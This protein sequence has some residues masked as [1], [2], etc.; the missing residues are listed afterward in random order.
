[1]TEKKTTMHNKFKEFFVFI[2]TNISEKNNN[3]KL[4]HPGDGTFTKHIIPEAPK[5]KDAKLKKKKGMQ[6]G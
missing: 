2:F 1:M 6:S 3:Y 5:E 4:R